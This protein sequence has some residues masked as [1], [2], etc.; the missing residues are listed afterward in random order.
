VRRFGMDGAIIFSD[1][2]VIPDALGQGV[3]FEAGRGPVLRAITTVDELT[4]FEPD[5]LREYLAPIYEAIGLVR[6]ALGSETALIGFAGAP[7]TVAAY[8]VEGGSSHTFEKLKGMAYGRPEDF[9]AL[10]DLLVEAIATHLIA[11]IDAGVEVVQIFDSWAGI[12][13][14][15][16][17]RRWSIEPTARIVQRVKARHPD[18]PIIGF[19]NRCGVLYAAYASETGVD[20]VSIDATVPLEWAQTML[21]PR[22]ALQGNLDPQMLVAGGAAMRQ[23]VRRII[24]TLGEGPRGPDPRLE[25]TGVRRRRAPAAMPSIAAMKPPKTKAEP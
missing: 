2:L 1:I 14:D 6:G 13:P 7:W 12:L 20:A 18:V 8:M 17:F 22:V 15:V 24:E 9:A 21:R 19:P 11:Q 23:D 5:D 25:R 4:T 10:I 3:A 16:H